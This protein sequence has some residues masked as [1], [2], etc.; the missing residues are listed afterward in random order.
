M[1]PGCAGSKWPGNFESTSRTIRR[2]CKFQKT[3]EGGAFESAL[4]DTIDGCRLAANTYFAGPERVC[5]CT[6]AGFA[7]NCATSGPVE[8]Q[9]GLRWPQGVFIRSSGDPEAFA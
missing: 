4:D 6:E 1:R 5:D 8:T 3:N 7:R 2:S 9:S